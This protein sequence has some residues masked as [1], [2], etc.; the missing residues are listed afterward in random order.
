[1]A[2]TYSCPPSLCPQ[3]DLGSLGEDTLEKDRAEIVWTRQEWL[4]QAKA[5]IHIE[6]GRLG[7]IANGVIEQTHVRPWSTVMRV[8]TRTGNVFFKADGQLLAKEVPVTLALSLA[9]PDCIPTVLSADVR[10]GWM[11]LEDG[12]ERLR[13]ILKLRRDL[14]HWEKILPVY[15]QLQVEMSS[16]RDEFLV[17]GAMDRR[18]QTLPAL[19]E[20]MLQDH[21]ALLVGS[22]SGLSRE[23]HGRLIALAPRV[24][25]MCQ[26]LASLGI[27]DSIQHDDFHDANILVRGARY[28]FFDW[29]DCCVTHPFASMLVA[30]RV[31][32]DR[33]KL[34]PND[35]ILGTL[36]NIYLDPWT[37][38]GSRVA[39]K[40]ALDLACRAGMICRA[41]AWRRV[42]P[43]LT[44][45]LAQFR[46]AVAEWM[47]EFLEVMDR[48][49]VT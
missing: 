49:I 23:H 20:E 1:M 27:R 2:G 34:D 30:K 33:L 40:E 43:Y 29:G 21:E 37:G 24:R 11:L 19:F 18:L 10:R 41:L 7:L 46:N 12:G 17:L 26:H 5:W 39:L 25:K 6:L 9:R 28:L 4:E 35:P 13:D 32:I 15:S 42:A 16:R 38:Y 14:S 22:P 3:R 48:G 47:V 44:G 36:E 45:E 31:M 8:P